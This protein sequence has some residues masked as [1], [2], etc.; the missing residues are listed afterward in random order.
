[1]AH[2]AGNGTLPYTRDGIRSHG[3]PS[4]LKFFL[5]VTV[6]CVVLAFVIVAGNG[7]PL[8]TGA[9]LIVSLIVILTLYRLDVGFLILLA[10]TLLFGQ[11]EVPGLPTFTGSVSY[12]KNLK[13]ISYLPY[14]DLGIANPFELQF[15]FIIGVWFALIC[16]KDDYHV[17]PVALWLPACLWF[18]W[19]VSAFVNGMLRGGDF[20]PA[21]WEARALMYL[22][23]IYVFVPQVIRTKEQIAAFFWV[24]IA[25]ISFKAFE[26]IALFVG[27]GWTMGTFQTLEAHEDPII[28]MTLFYLLFGLMVYGGHRRQRAVL[29]VLL[30]PVLLGFYVGKRRAAY[31]SLFM[32]FAGYLI[33]MPR[34]E[35]LRISK[36]IVP[37]LILLTVYTVVFWNSKGGIAGPL[38]QIKSGFDI[39]EEGNTEVVR[40]RDYLSNLYR[41]IE[42][43]DLLFTIRNAAAI[44]IGFGTKYEQPLYLVP[45]NFELRNY[46]AHNSVLWLMVKGGAT[47]FFLFWIFMNSLAFKG[48]SLFF[49]LRDPYLKTVLALSVVSVII[50][51]TAAFYDLHFVWYRNTIYFGTLLGLIA[52]IQNITRD[53]PGLL[54][55]HNAPSTL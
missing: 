3:S 11:F 14:S 4:D 26:G 48:A 52:S 27:N 53:H 15:L 23:V 24:A 45:L 29:L 54:D 18:T 44:G 38:Q 22:G 6:F 42:N 43:Y 17:R 37:G 1:M 5:F 28:M 12:F 41:K 49:R 55:Q 13:E 46:E 34:K 35:L 9:F 19:L 25:C 47:G 21:L 36:F 20:L 10:M 32:S 31:A 40:D 8:S 30:L 33:L 16:I 2:E 7:S 50:L 39:S 51:V